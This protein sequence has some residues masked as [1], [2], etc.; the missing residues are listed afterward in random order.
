[1]LLDIPST[2]VQASGVPYAPENYD[3]K[4]H[5]PVSLRVALA[6]SYNIPAVEVI[7]RVG[8]DNVIRLSHRMGIESLDTGQFGLAL[9]LCGGDYDE[10]NP[11]AAAGGWITSLAGVDG[12]ICCYCG[13]S[14]LPWKDSRWPAELGS[15][16]PPDGHNGAEGGHGVE[17]GCPSGC[18]C[19][20]GAPCYNI[21]GCW[22]D[23]HMC[24]QAT[25]GEAIGMCCG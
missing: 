7:N 8:I 15:Y 12:A 21:N 9:T 4:F 22:N 14:G 25:C 18:P 10:E 23:S 5:G 11:K 16:N 3:R 2:F 24:A 20:P 1:M 19:L 17:A 6:R 13:S